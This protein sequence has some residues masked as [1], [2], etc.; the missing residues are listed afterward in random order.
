MDICSRCGRFSKCGNMKVRSHLYNI[1]ICDECQVELN[2]FIRGE[3]LPDNQ[4]IKE[5]DKALD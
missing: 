1:P 2:L 4:Y 5:L 3:N